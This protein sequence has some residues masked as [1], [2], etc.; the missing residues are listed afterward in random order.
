[1]V[2]T[3]ITNSLKFN[4]FIF[5]YPLFLFILINLL[6]DIGNAT[7]QIQPCEENR[8]S[9]PTKQQY[10]KILNNSMNDV[11]F[12]YIAVYY[13]RHMSFLPILPKK[14]ISIVVSFLD[15]SSIYSLGHVSR[16][17]RIFILKYYPK[18]T[19]SILS[20]T[21]INLTPEIIADI[22]DN[23]T[24]ETCQIIGIDP[25]KCRPSDMIHKVFRVPPEMACR[26]K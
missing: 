24:D 11:L 15:A 12:I 16:F 22:L 6:L 2:S 10:L 8:I 17:F 18:L 7:I 13:T 1:M 14:L 20:T 19:S 26:I 23:M 5:R 3:P 9:S 4:F 21:R 25:K